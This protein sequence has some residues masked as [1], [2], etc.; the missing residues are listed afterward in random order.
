MYKHVLSILW[1]LS[2]E[3]IWK[4]LKIYEPFVCP[5][6]EM[7]LG[8]MVSQK[9]IPNHR[10]HSYP[11]LKCYFVGIPYFQTNPNSYFLRGRL[12]GSD[13]FRPTLWAAGT[14][15]R[16][17]WTS[18]GSNLDKTLVGYWNTWITLYYTYVVV[19]PHILISTNQLRTWLCVGYLTLA[20]NIAPNTLLCQLCLYLA[21]CIQ[22]TTVLTEYGPIPNFEWS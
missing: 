22:T 2:L 8:I 5:F 13:M 3:P 21:V 17:E 15:H 12:S 19:W 6:D 1:T 11:Y 20:M 18:W 14:Q 9:L 7:G 10:I 4:Q 16:A